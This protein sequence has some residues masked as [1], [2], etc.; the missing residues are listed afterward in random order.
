MKHIMVLAVAILSLVVAVPITQADATN[1]TRNAAVSIKT[2][3]KTSVIAKKT[4]A[5]AVVAPT[6]EP[7]PA[8]TP[9]PTP[10]PTPK[11]APQP[12]RSYN[13]TGQCTAYASLFAQYAWDSQTAMAI[14]Q[15][16]SGGNPNA[17]SPTDDY[18]LMQINHGL[19]IYGDKIYDPAFNISIAY[20][21]KFAN[22]GWR[23]WS[24][25]NS[26]AYLRYM[27]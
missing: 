3:A 27:K 4:E 21:A 19:E 18:G 10:V 20:S 26:G 12:T 13:A 16:E 9:E 14:C 8:P 25:Y 15:A 6:P 22:S 24:V 2:T 1:S 11:P 17:V 7:T 5:P 23:P